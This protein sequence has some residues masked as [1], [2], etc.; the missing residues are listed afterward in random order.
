M[1]QLYYER[2]H[3][4]LCCT[5]INKRNFLFKTELLQLTRM[6]LKHNVHVFS[7]VAFSVQ[8]VCSST[9]TIAVQHS[10]MAIL[11]YESESTACHAVDKLNFCFK[12]M[13]YVIY[14]EALRAAWP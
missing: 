5:G 11:S 1:S 6:N 12:N 9:E 4:Q 14:E 3:I 10:A 7:F 8:V 13:L 2:M